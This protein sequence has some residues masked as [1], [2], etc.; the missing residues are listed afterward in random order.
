MM[1]KKGLALE[2]CEIIKK[3]MEIEDIHGVEIA[4]FSCPD[5]KK[6]KR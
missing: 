5:Y 4:V 6:H 1:F 3:I 2:Y